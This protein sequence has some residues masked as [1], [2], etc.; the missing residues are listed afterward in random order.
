VWVQ[1][2]PVPKGDPDPRLVSWN[3]FGQ[4]CP[5]NRVDCNEASLAVDQDK[6]VAESDIDRCRSYLL[7]AIHKG[8]N[9]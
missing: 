4:L 5:L 6:L 7:I 3:I 9:Y 1:I 8:C 2:K